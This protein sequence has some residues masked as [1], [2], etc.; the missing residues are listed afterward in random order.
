[1][2]LVWL[3]GC[4]SQECLSA[5]QPLTGPVRH[6]L[7]ATSATKPWR[8]LLRCFAAEINIKHIRYYDEMPDFLAQVEPELAQF[9]GYFR[10]SSSGFVKAF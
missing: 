7:L 3:A 5:W 10:P 4:K 6:L 2:E 1:M 9:T 8:P